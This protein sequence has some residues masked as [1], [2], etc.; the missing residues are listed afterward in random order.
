MQACWSSERASL[1]QRE[2]Y[3]EAKVVANLETEM[4]KKFF[5]K[6]IGEHGYGWLN[7]YL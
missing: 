1:W 6:K 5:M 7:G 2:A 3:L 4:V